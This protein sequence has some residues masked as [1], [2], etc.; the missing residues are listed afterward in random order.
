MLCEFHKILFADLLTLDPLLDY[1][2]PHGIFNTMI[3]I[4]NNNNNN[5]L[6][7][8]GITKKGIHVCF[9]KKTE[10]PSKTKL[11]PYKLQLLRITYPENCTRMPISP[12]NM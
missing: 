12:Y 9:L 1:K 2:Q 7:V 6:T 5:I 4:Y 11:S 10:N 8:Y 3:L